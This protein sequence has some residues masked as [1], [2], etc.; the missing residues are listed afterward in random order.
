M[1]GV[2]PVYKEL[3]LRNAIPAFRAALL[4]RLQLL[5]GR[6]EEYF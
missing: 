6:I 2:K 3:A 1:S 4:F 5:D